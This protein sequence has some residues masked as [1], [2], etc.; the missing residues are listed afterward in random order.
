MSATGPVHTVIMPVFNGAAHIG[1]ALASVLPQLGPGDEILVVDNGSSDGTVAV[2]EA[3]GDK[4]IQ[5]LH[6]ARRGPA[7]ARN[8]GLQVARGEF[9]SF[10]DHDDY[11]SPGRLVAMTE[12]LRTHPGADAVVGHVRVVFDG[13]PSTPKYANMDGRLTD[14]I[15]LG[16][17]LFRA[18]AIRRAGLMDETLMFGEDSDYI[19]RFRAVSRGL[20]EWDGVALTYRRH[21][22]NMTNDT[23]AS[24]HGMMAMLAANIARR[25]AQK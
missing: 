5:L 4:R 10:L 9:I 19:I 1:E 21:A 20:V 15:I 16:V 22:G 24:D 17:Q 14:A 23:R 18:E 2:V 25:R 11:W 3:L 6:E 13:V 12:L 7:A 8:R